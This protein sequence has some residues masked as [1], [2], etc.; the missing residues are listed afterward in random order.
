LWAAY[1]PV[2]RLEGF[3]E[4]NGALAYS[5]EMLN[6]PM[7]EGD[8]VF[9]DPEWLKFCTFENNMVFRG[10]KPRD[11]WINEAL[12]VHVTAIDPA[13][14]G[15][16]YAAVVTVAVFNHDFFIREAWWQKGEG[17]RQ[18][19]VT[20][21]IRQAEYWNSRMLVCES[22]GAQI[23]LADEFVRKSRLPVE[24]ATPS[25]NKVDRALPVAIR[26]SQ[27]HIYFESGIPAVRA[28]REVLIQFPGPM[29]DDPVDGFVMAVE[30]AALLRS[31]FLVTS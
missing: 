31:K 1:W 27:G 16:D 20:E 28:L 24:K 14:G 8:K 13:Y 2:E 5:F 12:L 15:K 18:A 29:A 9:R 6:K 21:T 30:G 4:E 10:D 3:K 17:I 26:A 11:D 19:M 23:L 7:A 25:K 22:N